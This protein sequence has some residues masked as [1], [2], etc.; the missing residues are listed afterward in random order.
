[1]PASHI[2]QVH[3]HEVGAIDSIVDTA[4]VCV[5]LYLLDIDAVYASPL[6]FATGFA[7]TSHG[8]SILYLRTKARL[9]MTLCPN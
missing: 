9:Y 5:A 2:N 4:G 6:P 1:M 7:K 3:F 8:V